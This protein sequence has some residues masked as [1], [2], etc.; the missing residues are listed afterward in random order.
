[1]LHYITNKF[2]KFKGERLSESSF[3]TLVTDFSD[4]KNS[5][6]FDTKEKSLILTRGKQLA[7]KIDCSGDSSEWKVVYPKI[8]NPFD[9]KQISFVKENIKTSRKI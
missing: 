4:R 3:L 9:I 5:I 1:M 2:W 6:S 7:I 8:L